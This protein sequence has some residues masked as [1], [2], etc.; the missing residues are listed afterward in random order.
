MHGPVA[1]WR[2]YDR[3]LSLQRSRANCDVTRTVTFLHVSRLAV[4]ELWD[5]LQEGLGE[6][7]ACVALPSFFQPRALVSAFT[8]LRTETVNPAFRDPSSLE[9]ASKQTAAAAA[10]ATGRGGEKGN[11]S[12]PSA[13]PGARWRRSLQT[14]GTAPDEELEWEERTLRAKAE[15]ASPLHAFVWRLQHQYGVP[16]IDAALYPEWT[17]HSIGS[18][19]GAALLSNSLAIL[20][21]TFMV[22]NLVNASILSVVPNFVAYSMLLT[23]YPRSPTTVLR[24]LFGYTSAVII[25]KFAFQLPV[26]CENMAVQETGGIATGQW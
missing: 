6:D 3:I 10:A 5:M 11:A 24:F 9:E 26:F 14:G 7:V 18:L 17:D 16:L 8:R 1:F 21:L 13:G 25:L 19:L 20:C 4:A 2:R 22:Q 23:D 15:A 12:S